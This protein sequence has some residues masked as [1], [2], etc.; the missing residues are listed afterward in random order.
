M[1]SRKRPARRGRAPEWFTR[2][3]SDAQLALLDDPYRELTEPLITALGPDAQNVVGRVYTAHERS[4]RYYL[5]PR[6]AV[7][8]VGA[9]DRVRGWWRR[10]APGRR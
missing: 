1:G 6:A 4:T 3:D 7:E 10:L 9:R 8:L 2:L 5:A